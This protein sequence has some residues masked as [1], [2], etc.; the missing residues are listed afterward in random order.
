MAELGFRTLDEM[1]GRS[2]ILEFQPPEEHWKARRLDLSPLLKT[3]AG[4]WKASR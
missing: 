1:I 3:A 2:D 4:R